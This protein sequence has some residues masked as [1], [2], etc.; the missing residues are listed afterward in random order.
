VGCQATKDAKDIIPDSPII[1]EV[2]AWTIC[3]LPAKYITI[4]IFI[5]IAHKN[6]VA[7]YSKLILWSVL[8]S[9]IQNFTPGADHWQD[10][11]TNEN[12]FDEIV[13]KLNSLVLSLSSSE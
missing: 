5:G 3:W 4:T 10:T 7:L 2:F 13:F 12:Y 6:H 9:A 1:P 11:I 8:Q